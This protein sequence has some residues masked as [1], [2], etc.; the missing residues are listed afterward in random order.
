MENKTTKEL[1]Q[2]AKENRKFKNMKVDMFERRQYLRACKD[3][4]NRYNVGEA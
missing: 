1:K 3:L 2:I 4:N